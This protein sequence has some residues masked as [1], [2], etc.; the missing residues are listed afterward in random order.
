MDVQNE[1]SQ[2]ML[3]QVVDAFW[4][5]MLPFWHRVRDHIRQAAAERFDI[6]VEQFHVLRY[7]RRGHGSV[8]E[9]AEAKHISRPAVSQAVDALVERGLIART[10][11]TDDRRYVRLALTDAGNTLLDAVF[12]DTRQWMIQALT[13]LDDEEL[14]TLLQ[15]MNSLR[16]TES[17]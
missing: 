12:E 3:R 15:A 16:K 1:P 6:S 8:S 14:Y 11:D 10:R 4:E 5:T 17:L 2:E 9:L 13:P 7:I